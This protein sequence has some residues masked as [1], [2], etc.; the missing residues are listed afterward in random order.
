MPLAEDV[1]LDELAR[2]TYGYV[3]ADLAAITRE[4]GIEAVRRI[5][6]QLNLEEGTVPPEVLENLSVRRDDFIAAHKRVQ[7]SAL[8]EIMVQM[9]GV[10]WDDVGGVDEGRT[11]RRAGV[12]VPRQ[13]ATTLNHSGPN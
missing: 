4:A 1:D 5:M 9:P 10:R 12:D 7:P 8:R 6:P 11:R 13:T 2:I 3:G